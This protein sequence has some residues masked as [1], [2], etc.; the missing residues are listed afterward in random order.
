MKS[1]PKNI[2]AEMR[3][4]YIAIAKCK[5]TK[6][7]F[8]YLLGNYPFRDLQGGNKLACGAGSET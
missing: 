2:T 4:I 1:N 8:G 6:V 3:I 5:E 7:E